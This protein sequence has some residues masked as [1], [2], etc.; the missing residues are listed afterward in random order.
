MIVMIRTNEER[1]TLR[2]NQ[3]AGFVLKRETNV[4]RREKTKVGQRKI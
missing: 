1:I 2:T 3:M 4:E